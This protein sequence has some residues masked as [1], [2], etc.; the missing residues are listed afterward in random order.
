MV[1]VSVAWSTDDASMGGNPVVDQDFFQLLKEPRFLQ[2][3]KAPSRPSDLVSVQHGHVPSCAKVIGR[4]G[5]FVNGLRWNNDSTQAE[6]E[7][8][9]PHGQG[10]ARL[11]SR[12][13][14]EI[15][16]EENQV[17]LVCSQKL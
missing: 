9:R 15:I 2:E 12:T 5:D 4:A 3:T 6:A 11:A 16:L 1:A 8:M 13:C 14:S 10:F 17:I 7:Y